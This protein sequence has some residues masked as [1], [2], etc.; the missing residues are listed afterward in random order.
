MSRTESHVEPAIANQ[1]PLAVEPWPEAD[2]RFSH[3]IVQITLTRLREFARHRT[4]IFWVY[5]FPVLMSIALGIAFQDRPEETFRVDVQAGPGA[6]RV[7]EALTASQDRYTE[8]HPGERVSF[9]VKIVDESEGRRRLR[10]GT[11]TL[12][13]QPDPANRDDAPLI[14]QRIEYLYD[15]TRPDSNLA[16][17]AADEALQRAAG[18]HDPVAVRDAEFVEPGSRYIDFLIPG[19]LG[20]CLMTGGCWGVGF[21]AVDLRMRNLL[22]RLVTTPMQKSHLLAGLILSRFAFLITQVIVVLVVARLLFGVEVLGSLALLMGLAVLGGWMFAGVGLLAASRARTVETVSGILNLILM[23]MWVLSGVFFSSQRFPD[24]VQPFIK[25]LPLTPLIDS[26]RSVMIEGAT[27]GDV[28]GDVGLMVG[29][30]VGSF[31][32]ALRFFRWT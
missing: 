5:G 17:A 1:S 14:E 10:S 30:A 21:V 31:L 12:L 3:P 20:S 15:F 19:L 32:V 29:W 27:L 8:G 25:L 6:E 28:A 18:R 16:R 23:P 22:K 11:S 2:D 13:L 26:M 7:A 4:N 9:D 24:A